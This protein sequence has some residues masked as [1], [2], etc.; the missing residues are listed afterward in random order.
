MI[1]STKVNVFAT[2]S[3]IFFVTYEEDREGLLLN[4]KFDLKC[5]FKLGMARQGLAGGD[6]VR[7]VLPRTGAVPGVPSVSRSG[8]CT[9]I[10]GTIA[11]GTSS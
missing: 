4:P 6:A 1:L 8:S 3:A 7:S 11:S 5:G 10:L 2:L 9:K